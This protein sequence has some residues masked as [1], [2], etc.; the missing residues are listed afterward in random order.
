ML[1]LDVYRNNCPSLYL[2]VGCLVVAVVLVVVFGSE[3]PLSVA[4]VGAAVVVVLV[5][6]GAVVVESFMASAANAEKASFFSV[7]VDVVS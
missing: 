7:L 4:S 1:P 3:V 6:L 5:S 2:D